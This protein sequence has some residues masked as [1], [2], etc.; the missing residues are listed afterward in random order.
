MNKHDAAEMG[1]W[2]FMGVPY[3]KFGV[4]SLSCDQLQISKHFL[5]A[6]NLF[7]SGSRFWND[8]ETLI[9]EEGSGGHWAQ[10]AYG[11]SQPALDWSLYSSEVAYFL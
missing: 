3:G 8:L 6:S 4:A 2:F 1:L 7:F 11:F 10:I 5:F 9:R